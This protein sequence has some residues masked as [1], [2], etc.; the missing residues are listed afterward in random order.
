MTRFSIWSLMPRPWRPPMRLASRNSST[1]DANRLP[2]IEVGQPCSKPIVTSSA[3][4][5]TSGR[6]GATPMIG[7][8][9]RMPRVEP[10]EVLGLVGRAQHVGVG[11]VRLLDAHLVRLADPVQVLGHLGAAAEGA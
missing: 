6:H 8:T 2:L 11:R 1:R 9:M 5:A 4:I 7:S 10:L 3:A